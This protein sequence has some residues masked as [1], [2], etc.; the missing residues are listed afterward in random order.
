MIKLTDEEIWEALDI[1]VE[2]RHFR[3]SRTQFDSAEVGAKAQLKKV[4]EW[5]KKHRWQGH[6]PAIGCGTPRGYLIGEEELKEL[7]E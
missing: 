2:D 7:E 5:I 1:P 6:K 4:I 3:V